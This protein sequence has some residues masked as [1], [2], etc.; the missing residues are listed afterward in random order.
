MMIKTFD[1]LDIPA[2]GFGTWQLKGKRCK[3][4][5]HHA[6][7]I[8]YRHFDTAQLY[9]NEQ[10]VGQALIAS[11]ISRDEI[12]ITT[13]IRQDRLTCEE[14]LRSFEESL[15]K[16]G[17]DYCDL[18]L[19]HWPSEDIP[20]EE[21]LEA[22]KVLKADGKISAIGVSNFNTA[23]LQE[24]LET[25]NIM[26]N[27][28]EYN[29][30]IDQDGLLQLATSQRLMLTAYS[31]L[32]K[33]KVMED[34]TIQQ[35][36][37]RYGKNPVQVALRW[38]IQQQNV[39]AIPK[40]ADPGHRESNFQIFDFELTPDEMNKIFHLARD[41]QVVNNSAAHEIHH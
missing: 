17:T 31:P 32:A 20:L 13:K 9:D 28:V 2:L 36:G 19:I 4:A 12:F 33:G 15:E 40:A 10:E 1:R 8:G 35:I 18:L 3:E 22:M 23:L 37:K 27:Q 29:P 24:A 39:V 26:C 14:V 5:I 41:R 16:L 25:A 34:A 7:E 6:L 21:T 38:L 11:G 30:Y